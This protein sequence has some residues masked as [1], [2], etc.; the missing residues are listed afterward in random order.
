MLRKSNASHEFVA[1]VIVN[2]PRRAGVLHVLSLAPIGGI[3]GL[4]I[5]IAVWIFTTYVDDR[6]W[7]YA[8]GIAVALS[9]KII[10]QLIWLLVLRPLVP[11][12]ARPVLRMRGLP[13]NEK[14]IVPVEL[15]SRLSL[16]VTIVVTTAIA[17]ILATESVAPA[18]MTRYPHNIWIP[19][20]AGLLVTTL[21]IVSSTA[22]LYALMYNRTPD[23]ENGDTA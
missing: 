16:L 20:T 5:A 9:L 14:L 6:L 3:V 4:A 2:A 7:T 8:F 19:T 10:G 1:R 13:Q 15:S 17:T 23:Q 12:F 18:W 11:L 21:E 22:R